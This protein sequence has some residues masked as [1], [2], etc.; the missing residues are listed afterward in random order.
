MTPTSTIETGGRTAVFAGSFHPFTKGHADIACRALELF[1]HIIIAIGIN[2]SKPDAGNDT[3]ISAIKALYRGEPRISVET[4][5]GLTVDFAR[6]RGASF[7]LRG[8]RSVKDF[9]YERNL[10]DINRQLSGLETVILFSRPEYSAISSSVVREL[11]S[12]GHDV[13]QLLP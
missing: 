12:Y 7:L 4:Y 2:K 3:D 13:S 8:V 9:E 1:D 11:Q 5:S 6:A 10:A